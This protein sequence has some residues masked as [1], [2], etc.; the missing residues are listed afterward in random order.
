MV[1]QCQYFLHSF[2]KLRS[3]NVIQLMIKMY[4]SGI[5][6]ESQAQVHS[7]SWTVW[8][9]YI[10]LL[11]HNNNT[12]TPSSAKFYVFHAYLSSIVVYIPPLFTLFCPLNESLLALILSLV[13][14]ILWN[15]VSD[16]GIDLLIMFH[17]DGETLSHNRSIL[18]T[19]SIKQ[20]KC[21]TCITRCSVYQVWWWNDK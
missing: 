14:V 7:H 8:P 19:T 18:D 15:C 3:F 21:F 2:Q 10:G 1:S 13:A 9:S 6:A 20:C 16:F 5:R 12:T 4:L 17:H 11:M